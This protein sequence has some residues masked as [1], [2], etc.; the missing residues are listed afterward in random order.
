MSSRNSPTS[1]VDHMLV[2]K[3]HTICKSS[4]Y[5]VVDI[6]S[7]PSSDEQ[8]KQQAVRMEFQKGV[9]RLIVPYI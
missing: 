6:R 8:Q 2:L 5:Y 1:I 7:V 3:E 9:G 4:A